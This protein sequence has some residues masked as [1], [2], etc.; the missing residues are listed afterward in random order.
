MSPECAQPRLPRTGQR[1]PFLHPLAA[2]ARVDQVLCCISAIA[3]AS[4]S[5]L[6]ASPSATP[7]ALVIQRIVGPWR[8]ISKQQK[9][10]QIPRA[11][12]PI[13]DRPK[14]RPTPRNRLD[15]GPLV[16][17]KDLDTLRNA[18]NTAFPLAEVTRSAYSSLMRMIL[19]TVL[20]CGGWASDAAAQRALGI[21]WQHQAQSVV[22]ALDYIAVDYPAAVQDG[23]I[24]DAS[25]YAE[26]IEFAATVETILKD[27]PPRSQQ[28]ALI[29]QAAV[30]TQSIERR[31][32]GLTIS[33]Q[34]HRLAAGLIEVYSLITAPEVA[35]D[36]SNAAMLFAEHCAGCHGSAGAGDGPAG[37]ELDPSP[38][39][40]LNEK[41]AHQRSL[42]SLYATISFGVK[43]TGMASFAHLSPEERWA[44]AFYVAGLRDEA[45]SIAQGKRYWEKGILNDEV[46]TL[47]GFTSRTPGEL[48]APGEET[49]ST[50]AYLRHHPEVLDRP[51][52]NPI[53][54]TKRDLRE[55]LLAYRNNRP[56]LAL[57]YALTAYLE[58]Y[59]LIESL[60][61]TLDSDLATAIEH[62]LQALRNLIRDQASLAT[63]GDATAKL[64]LRLDIAAD[65]ISRQG[66][67]FSTLF[68]SALLIL[69]REGLEAILIVASM[70]MYL[71]RTKAS[72]G[73]RHLHFGWVAALAVGAL[74]W[75]GIKSIVNISGAQREVVE[76]AAAMLAAFVLLYVGLWMH[77]KG[78]AALW[79]SFLNENLGRSLSKGAL[80]GVTCL[81]FIAVYREFLETALF[82]ETLWLQSAQARPL[83][84]GAATAVLGL[85]TLSWLVFR[86]GTRLPLRRF[87]Q[88][89]GAL[90]FALSVVFAG[91]GVIA[92]QEAGWLAA[93]FVNFPRIDWLGL[94]PTMQSLGMQSAILAVGA[95]WLFSNAQ[96]QSGTQTAPS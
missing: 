31:A 2:Q 40:F 76:G 65:L 20:L 5:S 85:I 80:W 88:F 25:E 54:R 18:P 13:N 39:N 72:N 75:L 63:V 66:A 81:S 56:E 45:S 1:Y 79:Q 38:T 44:L 96:P 12:L 69:L 51:A 15:P 16:A 62:D 60:L 4:A 36:L 52:P 95:I 47:A 59:E 23:E 90:M 48:D 77:R 10:G 83:I 29:E 22:S 41:R 14:L 93:T 68:V 74:T 92:L 21:E 84:A 7:Q 49:A 34:C 27:L 94:Y 55:A 32:D 24:V 73:L 9:Q 37:A 42:Y 71:R 50:L 89:N 8:V 28:G 17:L 67:L 61:G 78:R 11:K 57:R 30:L 19:I 26:Q 86:A 43:N 87:F 3:E 58:G 35:P 46:P 53:E 91:K 33:D 70:G 82:Y 6:S 64:L